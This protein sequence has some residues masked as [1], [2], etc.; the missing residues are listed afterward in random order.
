MK[1]FN[2]KTAITGNRRDGL[3]LFE[4]NIPVTRR[5]EIVDSMVCKNCK[6][7]KKTRYYTFLVKLS[8]SFMC[9][10]PIADM[11]CQRENAVISRVL[12]Q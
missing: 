10:Q 11:T 7:K 4:E 8:L 12:L 3:Q 9:T 1:T 5:K 2:M 6:T